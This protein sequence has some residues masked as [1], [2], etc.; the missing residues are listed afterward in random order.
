MGGRARA[1]AA[2]AGGAAVRARR[3]AAAADRREGGARAL[4]APAAAGPGRGARGEPRAAGRDARRRPRCRARR[5]AP[6]RRSQRAAC[7]TSSTAAAAIL[8]GVDLAIAPGERVA[9]MGRNGAGKSTLLR[10]AAGLQEPTRGTRARRRARRAAAAEPGRLPAARARRRRGCRAAA[11]ER[12]GPRATSP[13][14][15]RATSPAASASGSRSRSCSAA[16]RRPPSLLLDEPTRGMDRAPRTRSPSRLR[17]LAGGGRR[18]ARRHAR[19]RVRRRRS[20]TRVVLLADGR[21]DRRRAGRRGARRRLVLRDRDRARARRCAGGGVLTPERGGE[22]LRARMPSRCARELG[23]RLAA[24]ARR[25]AA[26][27]ASPGT[28]ARHPT[29]GCSRSWRRS[30]RSPRSA[31]IAFAPLP[32]VKPTTDIVLIAGYVLGGAPGLRRSARSP[33][34]RR[35]S[36]FGQGP[37]T[38]W[39]MAAWGAAR[40]LGALLGARLRARLG[41]VPLALALRRG[42]ACS[43]ARSWTSRCG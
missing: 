10:H 33:R 30:P 9:L 24:R 12:G 6:G 19:R 40:V 23:A 31:A 3:A 1:R 7:G 14:A 35:T 5:R 16:R 8:R 4:R 37:W 34:W 27:P 20:P 13:S 29:R 36:F 25:R 22:L 2:D 26:R 32:N 11:L 39:Q 28:S 18:G 42:R 17:E 21:A 15:T 41:R 43:S 38:P